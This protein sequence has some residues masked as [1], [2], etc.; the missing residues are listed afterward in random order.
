MPKMHPNT[1]GCRGG[2]GK[3]TTFNWDGMEKRGTEREG[4]FP[5]PKV[6]VSSNLLSNNLCWL[7]S[8]HSTPVSFSE[9]RCYFADMPARG[10]L[11]SSTSSLLDVR[12]SRHATVADRSFATAACPRISNG[13][14]DDIM[15]LQCF[16]AVGWATGRAS[17]L[18][19]TEWW[20]AGMVICLELG[21]DLHM[22][23]LMPLPLTV[24]C[25]S[26]IQ[27][28]FTFL[29]PAHLGSPGKGR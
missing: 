4:E 6:K 26:K 14:P 21:A 23:Q 2:K 17:G 24:S 15:C 13:L 9:E 10:R 16:D 8:W 5:A 3:G 12:P 7:R 19:E 22:A 28:G 20:G 11:R 25:S 18:Q 1:F 27:I 29:V